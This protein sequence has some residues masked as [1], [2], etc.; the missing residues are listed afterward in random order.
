MALSLKHATKTQLAAAFRER[1]R[2]ASSVEC[3]RLA[4]WLLNRID[5]GDFTDAQ[6][7]SAF[8]LTAGQ[9]TQ[10]KNRFTNLRIAYNA[11]IAAQGE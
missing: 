5:E 7:Q 9:Y 8:G 4:T 2:N 3:A 6:V 10:M 1:Y 11:V